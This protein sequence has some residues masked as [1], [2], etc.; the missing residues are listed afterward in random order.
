L[1]N[2]Y[3]MKPWWDYRTTTTQRSVLNMKNLLLVLT[4]VITASPAFASRARLESL[5]EGKNGSY[6][7]NDSRN[8]F[9]NPS[10]IV[11]HKKKLMLELGNTNDSTT[12][13]DSVGTSFAQGGFINTFGDFTYAVYLNNFSDTMATAATTGVNVAPQ[14]AIEVQVA[15][16][17]AVNWGLGLT[18][19]GNKQNTLNAS[20]LGARAG[21]EKDNLA[22]FATVGLS[23]KITAGALEALKGKT[24]I[25]AGVTYGM[26]D[27]T[28]Y[29]KF[30]TSS[31]DVNAGAGAVEVANT[32][33]GAGLGWNKE[34]TKSTH[35][36]TRLEGNYAT[37]KTAGATTSKGYNVPVVLGA[38]TQA[39]S[40][41]A[42]RGSLTHNLLGQT[43]TGSNSTNDGVTVVAAGVGMTFGDVTI[44]GLVA[45]NGSAAA[46]QQF[47][48]GDSMVSR[49]AMTY[50]F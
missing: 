19:A 21:I 28:V 46:D 50:N 16:E 34:M 40:W 30:A 39:L 36:F 49:I 32:S 48:F 43:L 1:K 25:D 24:K 6:Y 12:G 47:G 26:D 44:D 18:T 33:F 11:K 27:M 13:A 3:A 15:G 14:N 37:A 8:M 9:L 45:N 31:N 5:G 23:S 42:V 10:S 2:E 38:E 35:M 29:G 4:L 22:V 41:L 7:I 17:G 20:Y